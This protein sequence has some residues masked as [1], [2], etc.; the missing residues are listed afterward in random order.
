MKGLEQWKATLISI[1]AL[2]EDEQGLS[3]G[4]MLT[5][6]FH[7]PSLKF[8]WRPRFLI[9]NISANDLVNWVKHVDLGQSLVKLGHHLESLVNNR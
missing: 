3:M 7:Q 1:E 6:K 8:M 5:V 9:I 4:E 2:L